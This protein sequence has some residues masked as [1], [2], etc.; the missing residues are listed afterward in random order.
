MVSEHLRS[1][2]DSVSELWIRSRPPDSQVQDQRWSDQPHYSP[3]AWAQ[4]HPAPMCTQQWFSWPLWAL[5]KTSMPHLSW[6]VGGSTAHLQPLGCVPINP[7][8]EARDCHTNTPK[9]K[10]CKVLPLPEL[11]LAWSQGSHFTFSIPVVKTGSQSPQDRDAR[12]C[13]QPTGKACPTS[14]CSQTKN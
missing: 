10:V 11:L 1:C 13:T 5:A 2:I 4:L 14:Y 3:S 12:A 7:Q 6:Q 9:T 8:A